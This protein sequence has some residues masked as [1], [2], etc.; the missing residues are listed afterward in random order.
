MRQLDGHQG[1]IVNDAFAGARPRV[2]W[3]RAAVHSVRTA[4]TVVGLTLLLGFGALGTFSS[5][6]AADPARQIDM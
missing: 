1:D 5:P 6:Q 4:S 3:L 2:P